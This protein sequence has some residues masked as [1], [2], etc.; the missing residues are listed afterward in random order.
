VVRDDAGMDRYR[1]GIGVAVAAL[2]VGLAAVPGGLSVATAPLVVAAALVVLG[3][4]AP[5][6]PGLRRLPVI[7]ASCAALTVVFDPNDSECV[8]DRADHTDP[9]QRDFQLRLRATNTGDVV[10]TNVRSRLKS[11]HD[12]IGRIRHDNTPPYAYSHSGMTLQAG[13]SDY[14]DVAF[15]HLDAPQ[16]VIQYADYYLVYQEQIVNRI[17]KADRTAVEVVIEGRRDDTSEWIPTVTKRYV[18]APDGNAIT[19]VEVEP[20]SGG[21]LSGEAAGEL[22]E[23]RQVSMEPDPIQPTDSEWK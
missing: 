6:I 20:Q 15:C 9:R 17:P 19:L 13:A 10:L 16:M 7:G 18:V 5:A 22:G 4:F 11:R 8:Q 14:F 3:T 1:A 23:N 2:L 21:S 12:Q